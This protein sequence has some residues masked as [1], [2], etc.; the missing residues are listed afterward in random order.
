MIEIIGL[1]NDELKKVIESAYRATLDHLLQIEDVY[2]EMTVVSPEE[3]RSINSETR[4]VDSVTDILSFPTIDA[5][6][7]SVRAEDYPSDVDYESG[8]VMMGE[9]V[10][11]LDRAREQ[12]EEYGHSIMREVGFLTTHGMLHLFG[13][14]HMVIDDEKEMFSKQKIILDGIGLVR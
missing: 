11:C 2:V 14:D 9:L 8:L 10:L 6:K 1:E 12:A 3:I 4:G 5:N 7:T 13:F